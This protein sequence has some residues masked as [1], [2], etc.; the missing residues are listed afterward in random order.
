MEERNAAPARQ[1]CALRSRFATDH[2]GGQT[3]SG[4]DAIPDAEHGSEPVVDPELRGRELA[5]FA[6]CIGKKP[7]DAARLV[8]I[9]LTLDGEAGFA[10]LALEFVAFIPA[11]MPEFLVELAEQPHSERD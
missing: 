5:A 1:T 9:E 10:H 11:E 4:D 2:H 3:G 8:E 7:G 6:E